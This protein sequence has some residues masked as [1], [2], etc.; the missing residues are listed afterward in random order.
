MHRPGSIHA[1]AEIVS[2]PRSG[3]PRR[4]AF[5]HPSLGLGGAERLVLDAALA[6]KAAGHDVR[7]FTSDF[8][9]DHCFEEARDGRLDVRVHGANIPA[10][11]GGRLRVPC[12]L[13]RSTVA[14]AATMRWAPDLVFCDTVAHVIPILRLGSAPVLFYGHFP[15]LLL[16]ARERRWYRWYRIPLDELERRG[17][18]GADRLLVNSLFT[19]GVFRDVFP[20][21]RPEV[22]YPGVA[23]PAA[24]DAIPDGPDIVLASINRFDPKKNLSLAIRAFAALRSRLDPPRFAQARLVL[25]GG[26]DRRMQEQLEE[27]DRLRRLAETL[28]VAEQVELRP[29]IDEAG[30]DALLASSRALLYTPEREHF[31]IVPLEAMAAGRPVVAVRSG[32]PLETIVDGETGFFCDATPDSFADALAL[33]VADVAKARQMG[34]NG[35]EHVLANFSGEVFARNLDA[36]VR[37]MTGAEDRTC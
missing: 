6:L 31:G 29:S 14:A 33:L 35:R 3:S 17:T 16:T 20:G 26:L 27:F 13:A 2:E 23:V 36:I 7:L 12:V 1:T 18:A 30:R 21:L 25:A 5:V 4:I 22:L 15:D 24:V 32:G 8:D 10:S 11:I 34:A 28:G 37:E 19:A 9:P